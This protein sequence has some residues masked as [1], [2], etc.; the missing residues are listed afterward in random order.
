MY[1]FLEAGAA[2]PSEDGD[3]A[4]SEPVS[5][6]VVSLAGSVDRMD[7][8]S[9]PEHQ[10][11]A[12]G[13][14][15]S[16]T[17]QLLDLSNAGE[18][19]WQVP[20]GFEPSVVQIDP[21]RLLVYASGPSAPGLVILDLK[22]GELV[23]AY[24]LPGGALD[25]AVDL[26]MGRI[27]A[28]I[29]ATQSVAVITLTQPEAR[30]LPVPGVPLA[31]AYDETNG[32]VLVSLAGNDPLGV[33]VVNP[34]NGEL[35][36]R[37][38]S[39]DTPEDIVIDAEQQRVVILNSGS[40]DLTLIDL[41][42]NGQAVRQI[43]LNWR[44]TRVAVSEGYAYVTSRD[45]DRLQ[46]VNLDT[47]RLQATYDTEAKPTGVQILDTPSGPGILLA[48]AGVPQ[49][50]WLSLDSGP[51]QSISASAEPTPVGT[52]VGKVM[53]IAQQA[54]SQG[55]LTVAPTPFFPGRQTEIKPDGTYLLTG[56]PAG[57]H[58]VDVE[59]PGFP[60]TTTQ[61]Q[62]RAGFVSTQEVQLPPSEMDES[63]SGIG[64]LPDA[65]TYSDELARHLEPALEELKPDREVILLDGPTGPD[66]RFRPLLPLVENLTL[67]DRDERY[68]EDL[69]KLQLIGNALGLRYIL[70][71]QLQISR[72][73]SRQGN[74][75][76]NTAVRFLVPVVPVEIPNFTPNMLRSRGLVVVV[77]LHQDSPGD[78]ARYYEAYGRDDVGG[79]PMY[80]DAAAGLFRLQVRNMIPVFKDQFQQ[81]D[82]FVD[83]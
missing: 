14:L 69:R 82:P 23:Q 44:P 83:G 40:Q 59:V 50:Q 52:V 5:E 31:T 71:T 9:T 63:V 78:Q 4:G 12:L 3:I 7:V 49:L 6:A 62:V 48:E 61:V 66:E 79:R 67:L 77:D 10:W 34:D 29:P 19:V 57:V 35:L 1:P 18:I 39:G 73:Y 22:T 80:E 47:G 38:R 65:P 21:V 30:N 28:T 42:S 75:L 41:K 8:L 27:F 24:G 76:L 68:T 15:E 58:L 74:G 64:L 11:V 20:V 55:T 16:Q 43:G 46:V 54:V 53:D 37:W 33:L 51:S 36:A 2:P 25:L 70:L 17:V 60:V 13:V 26:Q 72:D 81:T 32:N 45:N 56:L